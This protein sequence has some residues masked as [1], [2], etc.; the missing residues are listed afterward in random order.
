MCN[1]FG[2]HGLTK[3][4]PKALAN[5]GAGVRAEALEGHLAQEEGAQQGDAGGD[6]PRDGSGLQRARTCRVRLPFDLGR[7]SGARR[8]R[9]LER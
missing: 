4:Q 8:P 6:R 3:V 2:V 5:R 1:A 9:P 7:A